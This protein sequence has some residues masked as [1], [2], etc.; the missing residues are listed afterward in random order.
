MPILIFLTRRPKSTSLKSFASTANLSLTLLWTTF[1]SR[2]SWVSSNTEKL[3][4]SRHL[5]TIAE[6]QT[7]DLKSTALSL[8]ATCP[9]FWE[10]KSQHVHLYRSVS[11]SWDTSQQ[12]WVYGQVGHEGWYKHRQSPQRQENI[13]YNE[14]LRHLEC[15]KESIAVRASEFFGRMA[16]TQ[17]AAYQKKKI[18]VRIGE[19]RLH[20]KI[21]S[22]YFV[23]LSFRLKEILP[24][25]RWL[26]QKICSSPLFINYFS[27][28]VK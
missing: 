10:S 8:L 1:N 22:H 7:I 16:M 27:N 18:H 14:W 20:L 2:E 25:I 15:L 3:E 12:T 17:A 26:L 21:C 24:L 28:I 19:T 11:D 5:K 13:K 4:F 6:G 9:S 23:V